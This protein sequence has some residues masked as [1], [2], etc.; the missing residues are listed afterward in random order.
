MR[1]RKRW[2]R[3]RRRRLDGGEEEQI[4]AVIKF[5]CSRR[6]RSHRGTEAPQSFPELRINK[7]RVPVN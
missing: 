7:V 3:R 2:E 5:R 1:C 4:N 6:G